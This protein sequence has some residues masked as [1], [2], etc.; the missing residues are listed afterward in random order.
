MSQLDKE[1]RAR[2]KNNKRLIWNLFNNPRATFSSVTMEQMNF[3]PRPNMKKD[4]NA[5]EFIF[6]P[7]LKV[8]SDSSA[9][10]P[11]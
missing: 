9:D 4:P 2:N 8:I 7:S 1:K 10:E 11:C 3:P 5:L 6:R